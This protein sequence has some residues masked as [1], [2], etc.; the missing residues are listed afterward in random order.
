MRKGF[1]L[2]ELL[3]V[4]I[5][6]G[7]LATMAVPQ[8]QKMVNRAKWAEVQQLAGSVK[9][10][11]SLY[12]AEYGAWRTGAAIDITD[13]QLGSYLTLPGVGS[14]KSVFSLRTSNMIYGQVKGTDNTTDDTTPAATEAWYGIDLNT[15]TA[16]GG[17]GYPSST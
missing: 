16:S 14:R 12:Y 3:I 11:Q 8:Y 4:I 17:G 6:I 1:T 13:A 15:N 5:I 10:A 2:V 9:T 7:I